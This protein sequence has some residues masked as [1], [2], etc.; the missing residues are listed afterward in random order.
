M[1]FSIEKIANFLARTSGRDKVIYVIFLFKSKALPILPL[2]DELIISLIGDENVAVLS[3]FPEV[4][5]T[6]KN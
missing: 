6:E 1:P 4:F 5:R 3:A 2:T